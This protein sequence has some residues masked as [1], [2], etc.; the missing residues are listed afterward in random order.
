M[1]KREFLKT[2]GAVAAAMSFPLTVQAQGATYNWKMATGWGGGPL[3]DI[4]TKAFADKLELYSG[5]RFKIQIFPGGA[6]GNALKVQKIKHNEKRIVR[7]CVF[8]EIS[9]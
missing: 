9:Y 1:K 3:T 8:G 4:G 6:L 7:E 5:G 2:G